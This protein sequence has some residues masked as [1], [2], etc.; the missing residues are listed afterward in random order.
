MRKQEIQE[1]DNNRQT[2][3]LNEAIS[4]QKEIDRYKR[5]CDAYSHYSGQCASEAKLIRT[6][7]NDFQDDRMY[8]AIFVYLNRNGYLSYNKSFEYGIDE[9]EI[10]CNMGLSVITGKGVCR[11]ISA[12]FKD[13]LIAIKHQMLDNSKTFFV[14]TNINEERNMVIPLNELPEEFKIKYAKESKNNE[15]LSNNRQSE[16]AYKFLP[17]HAEIIV[18]VDPKKSTKLMMYDPTNIRITEID[19]S[20]RTNERRALDLRSD[21]WDASPNHL[22]LKDREEHIKRFGRIASSIEASS[23]KQ[24]TKKDMELILE[25]ARRSCNKNIDK[26]EE[27]YK[28]SE[29]WYAIIKEQKEKYYKICQQDNKG[30]D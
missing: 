1:Y 7:A 19:F 30:R 28:K 10:D 21:I 18:L 14:G 16:T 22:T 6:L 27:F 26:I 20:K 5:K 17:N 13:V 11:N 4:T 23:F 25:Y 12:H 8:M 3:Y 9:E 15:G 2:I 24:Y 29:K